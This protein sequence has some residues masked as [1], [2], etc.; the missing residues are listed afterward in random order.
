MLSRCA[1]L[2]QGYRRWLDVR[3]RYSG[4]AILAVFEAFDDLWVHVPSIQHW[5]FHEGHTC[6]FYEGDP[7]TGRFCSE[8]AVAG[9]PYCAHHLVQTK[10]HKKES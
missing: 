8:P 4:T 9:K 1:L 3:D 10:R 6:R 7:P 2:Q 5:R